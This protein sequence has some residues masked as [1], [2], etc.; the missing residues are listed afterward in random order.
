V[1]RV[2]LD[3]NVLVSAALSRSPQA[4]SALIFDA[5]LD[6]QLSLITSPMLIAEINSV[7]HRPRLRR[8]LSITEAERFISDLCRSNRTHT[9]WLSPFSGHLSGCR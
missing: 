5:A 4:P 2:I 9:G 3:A 7:I 8:Y 1:K 6:G